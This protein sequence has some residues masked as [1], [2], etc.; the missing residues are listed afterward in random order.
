MNL[1]LNLEAKFSVLTFCSIK[2]VLINAVFDCRCS[3]TGLEELAQYLIVARAAVRF[4]GYFE[5]HLL[6]VVFD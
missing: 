1:C 5:C 6:A 4:G 3:N 2:T